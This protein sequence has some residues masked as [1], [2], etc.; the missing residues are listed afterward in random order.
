MRALVTGASGQLGRDAAEELRLRGSEV[1]ALSH[2]ELDITDKAA[3]QKLISASRP[4]AVIH[5]AAYT[6]VDAAESDAEKCFSVNAS[7]TENIAAACQEAG[8]KLIYV[9]T[10]YVFD[11]SGETPWTP[12]AAPGPLNVY[13]GSKLAGERLAVAACGRLFIVRT[14]WLFGEHGSN[15]IKAILRLAESGKTLSV[16]SD[17]IGRPTYSKDLAR[18]LCDMAESDKYGVYHACGSGD[19]VSRF[20]I[21]SEAVKIAGLTAAGLKAVTTA[22]YGAAPA[23]RPLNSRLD[24]S[25]LARNGFEPLPDW[26]DAAK[27]YIKAIGGLRHGQA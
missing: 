1:I 18:L 11:G 7:G 26:R 5:C 6:A 25:K 2:R 13:G 12:E 21:A 22:E 16:V 10:D 27:R 3:V 9:S 24:V 23:A 8:A 15:F 4:D 20:E 17:Q 14:S 19:D